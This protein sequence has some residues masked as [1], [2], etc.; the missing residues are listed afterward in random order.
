MIIKEIPAD[1]IN[2]AIKLGL[3]RIHR[4]EKNV[5]DGPLARIYIMDKCTLVLIYAKAVGIYPMQYGLIAH[6]DQNDI[7]ITWDSIDD[8]LADLSESM[9]TRCIVKLMSEKYRVI[10][11]V[12]T[13]KRIQDNLMRVDSLGNMPKELITNYVI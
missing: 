9:W 8:L 5:C 10:L 11:P 6:R 3:D 2:G 4:I 7:Y 12:P 1:V 13:K